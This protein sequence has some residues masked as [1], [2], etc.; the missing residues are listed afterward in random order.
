MKRVH[1]VRDMSSGQVLGSWNAALADSASFRHEQATC[2]H[3]VEMRAVQT[4]IWIRR[5]RAVHYVHDYHT[6][7]GPLDR[8]RHRRLEAVL[9]IHRYPGYQTVAIWMML[10][11]TR[12]TARTT[13]RS[14]PALREVAGSGSASWGRHERSG[15]HGTDAWGG[16]PRHH[17]FT[18]RSFSK[19]WNR[20][21]ERSWS[22]L[23]SIR[24]A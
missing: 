4:G 8:P 9:E 6:G 21:S 7:G 2:R 24:S 23:G 12:K 22:H 17:G 16:T 11:R 5:H 14:R 1:R 3:I 10:T 19:A 20:G 18:S 15:P 13:C